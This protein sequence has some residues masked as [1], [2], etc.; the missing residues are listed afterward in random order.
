MAMMMLDCMHVN[1]TSRAVQDAMMAARSVMTGGCMAAPGAMMSTC[2]MVT[3]TMRLS[4]SGNSQA[5]GAH[6]K[7]CNQELSKDAS[8]VV[9]LGLHSGAQQENTVTTEPP[10]N[11][12]LS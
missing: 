10:M 6:E 9:L 8:H 2:S 3:A 5:D 4:L 11:G 1:V 7:E 12:S